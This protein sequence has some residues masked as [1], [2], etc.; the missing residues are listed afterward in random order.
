MSFRQK[1][2]L[3]RGSKTSRNFSENGSSR[4]PSVI[5]D[6]ASSVA[7]SSIQDSRLSKKQSLKSLKL[8]HNIGQPQQTPSDS[9]NSSG[10][11]NSPSD[12]AHHKKHAER[13]AKAAAEHPP[14]DRKQ[15]INLV[16]PIGQPDIQVNDVPDEVQSSPREV[17]SNFLQAGPGDGYISNNS[18]SNISEV[19]SSSNHAVDPLEIEQEELLKGDASANKFSLVAVTL[20]E[21]ALD[22]PT[23]RASF[24][25]LNNEISDMLE[26]CGNLQKRTSELNTSMDTLRELANNIIV[27]F[28]PNFAFQGL[29]G[30]DYT[31]LAFVRYSQSIKAVW[32]ELISRLH[33]HHDQLK[34]RLKKISDAYKPYK[35]QFEKFTAAQAAYDQAHASFMAMDKTETPADLQKAQ[36]H[37]AELRREYLLASIKLSNLMS[38]LRLEATAS[39]ILAFA[40]PMQIY[41]KASVSNME[42]AVDLHRLRQCALTMMR[43]KNDVMEGHENASR[44]LE[45]RA[46]ESDT[47]EDITAFAPENSTLPADYVPKVTDSTPLEQFGWVFIKHPSQRNRW[48]RRWAF[49]KNGLFGWLALSADGTYVLE[50]DKVAVASCTFTSAPDYSRRGCFTVTKDN[51]RVVI[52]AESTAELVGW[53]SVAAAVSRMHFDLP[54]L[55]Q[56]WS[57][58]FVSVHLTESMDSS[59]LSPSHSASS[60]HHNSGENF[61]RFMRRSAGLTRLNSHSSKS[62][63]ESLEA[64]QTTHDP[65]KVFPDHHMSSSFSSFLKAVG[66]AQYIDGLSTLAPSSQNMLAP[67]IIPTVPMPTSMTP[68]A[69]VGYSFLQPVGFP[70]ALT[71]NFWGSVN[72]RTYRASQQFTVE[73]TPKTPQYPPYYPKELIA[74][75]MIRRAIFENLNLP[76]EYLVTLIRGFVRLKENQWVPSRLYATNRRLLFQVSIFDYASL[77]SVRYMSILDVECKSSIDFD[78]LQVIVRN[79]ETENEESSDLPP[80]STFIM[81]MFIDSGILMQRRLQYLLDNYKSRR[82]D[83]LE[84]IIKQLGRINAEFSKDVEQRL[85]P[86]TEEEQVLGT[87]WSDIDRA[88]KN[89]NQNQST[90]TSEKNDVEVDAVHNLADTMKHKVLERD[91]AVSP[92]SLFHVMFGDHETVFNRDDMEHRLFQKLESGQWYDHNGVLERVVHAWISG[93]KEIAFKMYWDSMIQDFVQRIERKDSGHLYIISERRPVLKLPHGTKFTIT[94]RYAIVRLSNGYSRLQMFADVHWRKGQATTAK[95]LERVMLKLLREEMELTCRNID[96][97]LDTMSGH[98]DEFSIIK[99]FGKIKASQVQERPA[100]ENSINVHLGRRTYFW[101]AVKLPI[102]WLIN[103]F[104]AIFGGIGGYFGKVASVDRVI[105]LLLL[106]SLGLNFV[107]FG[108]STYNYWHAKWEVREAN[109]YVDNLIPAS[110]TAGSVFKR[111][112]YLRDVDEAISAGFATQD[113]PDNL[114]AAKFQELLT[115]EAY[116]NQE[117]LVLRPVVDYKSGQTIEYLQALR[118]GLAI[119]RNKLMTELRMLKEEE[120]AVIRREFGNWLQTENALCAKARSVIP[121]LNVDV[122]DHIKQYC[123]DCNVAANFTLL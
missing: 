21:A 14:A 83:N 122:F 93:I 13:T 76:N 101:Y 94:L 86:A 82:P 107:M 55:L 87:L 96:E 62:E 69:V 78:D 41:R 109:S 30:Q 119:E 3:R 59:N 71:A 33:T 84:E 118:T 115:T 26:W 68:W 79:T 77:R 53:L 56:P 35:A 38:R 24:N 72:W 50:S 25:H 18:E 64:E 23:F 48:V 80:Y 73:Y 104:V 31:T 91:F 111:A 54:S 27:M 70:N 106:V 57:P 42:N 95:T 110:P 40:D 39:L 37:T 75:D 45:Q 2:G 123:S 5:G 88:L 28:V 12:V 61:K 1:I 63:T 22:S 58:E 6:S 85:V 98:L 46:G 65:T 7:E 15:R 90:V 103:I 121:D 89:P 32:T 43:G 114:C 74:Q 113:Y 29:L 102:N 116:D 49:I 36:K 99:R 97:S 10:I 34:E 112:I 120:L 100:L 9:L 117:Q 108:S 66:T 81:R 19:S 17:S 8:L 44:R 16:G 11:E 105:L 47:T 52:Q 4:A 51:L 60:R 20:K 92:R 67:P